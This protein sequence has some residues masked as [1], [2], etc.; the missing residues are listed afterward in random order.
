ML[1]N[2]AGSLINLGCQWLISVLIVRLST[3][4]DSAGIYSLA[5]STYN[6]FGSVAQYR[7]YTY[8]V[9]DV[10]NENTTGEYLTLRIIT[11]SFA[12]VLCTIYGILTCNRAAWAA[13]FLYGVYKTATLIVDVFHA[14]DQRYHRM[15]FIGISLALQGSLGLIAFVAV[16]VA[17]Q[18]VELSLILMTAAV[19][20]VGAVFDFK[21]TSKFGTIK[22]GIIK[23]KVVHLLG[24]CLPVVIA[25]MAASA[26]S[27]LPRQ[28]LANIMGNAV[29]GAYA[30]VAAP[31]AIIQMG[32][33]YIYN[34]LLGYFSEF[35]ADGDIKN[36]KHLLAKGMGGLAA[37]GLVCTV[38]L[39]LLGNWLL[40][41]VFGKSIA[42]YTYLL[43]PLVLFA[44]LT[45]MQWFMN[46]LLIALRAF[47]TTFIS[48]IAS[49]AVVLVFETPVIEVFGPN[50]V[51]LVGIAA[52]LIGL[53][54]M[55]ARLVILL[56][57]I[58]SKQDSER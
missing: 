39:A 19:L 35:Y 45:G 27:S 11:S 46:D 16:F 20:V 18:S 33:S 57:A 29:L 25:G 31:V 22:L 53:I 34:P 55:S 40:I 4:Y 8:Q 24:S 10:K 37:V 38:G 7:M 36:F 42:E 56:R 13:I 43:T 48:S 17:A 50:G 1:W 9:S 5:V 41:L 52:C 58:E 3:G 32:A 21:Q 6:I 14:C 44:I 2:S 12:L 54:I 51:T 28:A 15:D 47:K 30:S 23:D 49:L 26:T